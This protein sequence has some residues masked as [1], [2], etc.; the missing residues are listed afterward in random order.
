MYAWNRSFRTRELC[1]IIKYDIFCS[2]VAI[3]VMATRNTTQKDAESSD[4][5]AK[6]AHSVSKRCNSDSTLRLL[7]G[8]SKGFI[9]CPL[10]PDCSYGCCFYSDHAIVTYM[11]NNISA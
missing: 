5:M 1:L 11:Y 6:D 3:R 4:S 9:I 10:Q 7:L 2:A 8:I